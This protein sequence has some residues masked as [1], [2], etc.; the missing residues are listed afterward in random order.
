M[1]ASMV[2]GVVAVLFSNEPAQLATAPAKNPPK[3]IQG[4][5]SRL[6]TSCAATAGTRGAHPGS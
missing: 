5:W 6:P 2:V 1:A 3:W 4:G